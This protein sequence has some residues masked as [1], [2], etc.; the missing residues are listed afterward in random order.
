[1][2]ILAERGA[3][4]AWPGVSAAW[5]LL[6]EGVLPVFAVLPA[7]V[8]VAVALAGDDEAADEV[9]CVAYL[10]GCWVMERSCW[11][12]AAKTEARKKGR[13]DGMVG[14]VVRVWWLR[15][16]RMSLC[17]DGAWESC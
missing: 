5:L 12:R 17:P 6:A 7:V 14:G 15:W 16:F 1:M 13:W 11:R 3:V 10:L 8:D 2:G 4:C 9:V